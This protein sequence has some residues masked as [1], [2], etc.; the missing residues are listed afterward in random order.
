MNC[1]VTG[2][3]GA[4]A[5]CQ[6]RVGTVVTQLTARTIVSIEPVAGTR[7]I[8]G[9]I[10]RAAKVTFGDARHD[11]PVDYGYVRIG[12]AGPIAI[13]FTATTAALFRRAV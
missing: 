3:T 4:I 8:I 5:Q 2:N 10:K 9:E 1:G 7:S 13:C 6:G 12:G 11:F